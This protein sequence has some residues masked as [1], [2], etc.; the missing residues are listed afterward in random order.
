MSDAA[1]P[2]GFEGVDRDGAAAALTPTAIEAILADFRAWLMEAPH[3]T[4]APPAQPMD[5]FTLVSQFTA[6]RH[7]V[8]MQTRAVRAVVEQNAEV[9]K[10]LAA[11]TD[12]DD[13]LRP[14]AKA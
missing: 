11:P 14:V 8:N 1:A 5:L 2:G 9:V 4:A 13:Q 7:E 6:L 12:S 10:Q 3:P